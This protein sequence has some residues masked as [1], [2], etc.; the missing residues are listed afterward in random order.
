VAS[1]GSGLRRPNLTVFAA[2]RL[3]WSAEYVVVQPNVDDDFEE[4]EY[5]MKREDWEKK[6]Q[7]R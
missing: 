1:A 3:S 6:Y 2:S 7:N 5:M 4:W